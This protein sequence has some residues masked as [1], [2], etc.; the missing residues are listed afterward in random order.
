MLQLDSQLT[1]CYAI[2]HEWRH[3]FFHGTLTIWTVTSIKTVEIAPKTLFLKC[4]GGW[5]TTDTIPVDK[6][7]ITFIS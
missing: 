6:A 3:D 5:A 2:F 7:I 4:A 1:G